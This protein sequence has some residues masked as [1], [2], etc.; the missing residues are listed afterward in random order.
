M[1]G[2][3]FKS[4]KPGA[5]KPALSVVRNITIGRT[6][7]LDRLAW[8]RIAKEGAFNLDRDTLEITAQGVI[9]LNEGDYVHR[10]YTDDHIMLQAVSSDQAGMQANDFTL[11]IPWTSHYPANAAQKRNW[12]ER[13]SA[14]TFTDEGLE[15]YRRYWFPEEDGVQPPVTFWEE[16]FTD[17]EGGKPY[18]RIY[19]SCMLYSR[20]IGDE[21]RELLLAIAM[22]TEGGDYSNEVMVGVPLGMAEF[23][24]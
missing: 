8:R 13:I 22:D 7:V 21:G 14:P 19:Q 2:S 5:D 12:I 4:M 24:A 9:R 23:K 17:R 1:F 16:V 10:F 6:V 15:T 20:E 3:L 18:A 11:F